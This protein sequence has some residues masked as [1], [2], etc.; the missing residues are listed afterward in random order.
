MT[1]V[2]SFLC[3][4]GVVVA[5]DSMLTSSMGNNHIAHHTGKKVAILNGS[6]VFAYAGDVGFGA[7]FRIMADS[8]HERIDETNHPIDHPIFLTQLILEQ[9]QLTTGFKLE[10]F[11]FGGLLSAILAYTHDN[12][13]HCCIFEGQ[14]QPRLLDEDHFYVSLGSGKLAAD[15]F[16]RF[17]V[18]GFCPNGPPNVREGVFLATWAVEYVIQTSPGGV[19]APIRIGVLSRSRNQENNGEYAAQELPDSEIY[20]H[21][22]AV[23][24]AINSLRKW[25][26][27]FH[28]ERAAD[29]VPPPPKPKPHGA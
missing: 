7:R 10:S 4:D 5:T 17:L 11:D 25:K 9:F 22:Q 16:L 1:V 20:E 6:Q 26:D 18:D 28:Q 8:S 19:A 3:T 24:S 14:L 12:K 15:P 13:H 29:D 23:E 27:S 21:Q 2:V